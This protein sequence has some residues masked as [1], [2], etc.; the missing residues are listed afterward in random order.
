MNHNIHWT[1]GLVPLADYIDTNRATDIIKC[2]SGGALF[3]V[4]EGAGAT[5]TA[6]IT[7]EACDNVTPSNTTAIPFIY[8]AMTTADTWGA[9]TAATT[10]GFGTT[11]GA[12]HL[13]EI[14]ADSAEMAEEGYGY[15]RLQLTELVNGAVL[16]GVIIGLVDTRYAVVPATL[17]T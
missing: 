6:T 15:V 16:G 11:A 9:W 2:E 13:Y 1:N 14:Y 12:N 8:R 3:L 7:I 17:I 10:A 5:G 4:Y